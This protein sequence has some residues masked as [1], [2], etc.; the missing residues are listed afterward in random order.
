MDDGAVPRP[1]STPALT[2]PAREAK[3]T[4]VLGTLDHFAW[5]AVGS[6]S[7]EVAGR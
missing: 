3:G 5:A 6:V 4:P 1:T 7:P 2:P